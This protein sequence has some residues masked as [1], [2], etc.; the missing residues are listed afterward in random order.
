MSGGRCEN[1]LG[2]SCEKSRFY[3]KKSYFSI[4]V[5]G[6][7]GPPPS[8]SAPELFCSQRFKIIWLWA[9]LSVPDEGY[10]RNASCALDLISMFLFV[11]R[12]S[13]IKHNEDRDVSIRSTTG[14]WQSDQRQGC[15][16]QIN[17]RD[18]SIRSTTGMCQSDQRQGCVNQINDILLL[19]KRY[20]DLDMDEKFSCL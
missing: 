4:L 8:G 13:T 7:G 3:A 18:V 2:I 14:M 12:T 6:R 16:N 1:C 17:D 9:S 10:S 19:L 15:V 11:I 20:G 5:G